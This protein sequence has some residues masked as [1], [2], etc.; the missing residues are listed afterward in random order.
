[1]WVKNRAKSHFKKRMQTECNDD[2]IW[3]EKPIP[4]PV[5]RGNYRR[6]FVTIRAQGFHT[7]S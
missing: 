5:L 1:M 3:A 7:E 6:H 2:W 4:G